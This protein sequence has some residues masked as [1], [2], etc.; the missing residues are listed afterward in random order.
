[1]TPSFVSTN[2]SG[3]VKANG[4]GIVHVSQM[5]KQ[6]VNAMGLCTKM[7]GTWSHELQAACYLLLP[8]WFLVKKI[9]AILSGKRKR[10]WTHLLSNK[11]FY[12]KL[13]NWFSNEYYSLTYTL[14]IHAKWMPASCW[15]FLKVAWKLKIA[16]EASHCSPAN[17][18]PLIIA[19]ILELLFR[20]RATIV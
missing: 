4:F 19:E 6:T 7:C 8:K 20:W 11:I 9:V 16:A 10:T 18:S 3:N 15:G 17:K 14:T 13:S 12:Y 2:M 5:A 1:M